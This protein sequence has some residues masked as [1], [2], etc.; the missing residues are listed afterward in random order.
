MNWVNADKDAK[1][2]VDF[3]IVKFKI[4]STDF[5]HFIKNFIAR[6]FETFVIQINYI[7]FK[8]KST[9]HITLILNAAT[10]LLFQEFVSVT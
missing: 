3:E 10:K 9:N 4:P 1:S 6:Y 8:I 2:A 7:L 5:E